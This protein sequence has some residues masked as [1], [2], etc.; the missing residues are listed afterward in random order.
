MF[1]TFEGIDGSGKSTQLS[2]LAEQLIHGGFSVLTTRDPGGTDLGQQL[3]HIL[4][5]HSGFV[6]Q[7]CELFLYLADRAQHVEELIQPALARGNIVLCDRFIDSTIAYQG[8]GRGLSIEEI[9][10]LNMQA[11]QGLKPDLTFL[12]DA[13]AELLLQ[14]A[15]NRSAADRFEQETLAFYERVRQTYLDLA[16]QEPRR[17]QILDASLPLVTLSKQ[18]D[19]IVQGKLKASC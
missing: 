4:L 2:I 15:K 9:N 18:V 8:G 19:E 13:P 7:R 6:S 17:I 16:H 12:F 14:R 11:T 5:H 10:H 3:R 1:I